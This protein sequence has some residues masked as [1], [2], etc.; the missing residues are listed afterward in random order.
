MDTNE[1]VAT[2]IVTTVVSTVILYWTIR[3]SVAAAIRSVNT[4]PTGQNIGASRLDP[5]D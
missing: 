1:L 2:L 4:D 5:D 3:L